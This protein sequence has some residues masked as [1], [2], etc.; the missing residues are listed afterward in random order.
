M[1]YGTTW[2]ERK[3]NDHISPIMVSEK[4]VR[5]TISHDIGDADGNDPLKLNAE[6][7]NANP[8]TI[9]SAFL[10]REQD[11]LQMRFT[12]KILG[13]VAE[14]CA[15]DQPWEKEALQAIE[16]GY[17]EQYHFNVLSNRYALNIANA[18]FLWRNR[19]GAQKLEVI[20]K[21]EAGKKTFIFDGY[22]FSLKNFDYSDPQ[23]DELSNM[24][25]SVFCGDR[26]YLLLDITVNALVG[27]GQ[28][29]FPSQELIFKKIKT[30]KN[31]ESQKGKVLYQVEGQAAMHSQKIGNAIRQIDT[32][33][34]G[35]EENG[36]RPIAI[37]PYGAVTTLAT[38][39]RNSTKV[40]FYGLLKKW[41]TGGKLG[42]NEQHFVMA[43]LI[44]GGV[45]GAN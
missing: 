13:Q 26:S 27:K 25:A 37:E 29:V 9:D 7:E 40:H 12:L 31:G 16:K 14:P 3:N 36:M 2:A 34:P 35:Y 39:F 6:L 28:E 5:G 21:V 32:W 24:I 38:A 33:Y 11:T 1:L 30:T 44:R 4:T 23:V 41:L 10:K 15:C 8:Q 43:V 19:V 17:I 18:R 42:E 20:V 45:F 22:Q